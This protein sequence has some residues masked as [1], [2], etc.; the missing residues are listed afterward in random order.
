MSLVK[1]TG[2]RR[3]NAALW[4]HG[5]KYWA[6]VTGLHWSTVLMCAH[7]AIIDQDASAQTLVDRVVPAQQFK[8]FMKFLMRL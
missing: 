6:T 2:S 3:A 4:E 8:H 5:G 7:C 1:A